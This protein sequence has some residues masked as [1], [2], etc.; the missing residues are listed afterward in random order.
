MLLIDVWKVPIG[1]SLAVIASCITVAVVA[2]LRATR[3]PR[4]PEPAQDE[5]AQP[6]SAQPDSADADSADTHSRAS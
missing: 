5:S 2:S 6:G 3:V 4:E 1:L